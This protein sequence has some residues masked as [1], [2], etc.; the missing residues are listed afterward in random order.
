MSDTIQEHVDNDLSIIMTCGACPESYDVYRGNDCVG[1][2]RLRHGYFAAS[3]YKFDEVDGDDVVYESF[4]KGDGIF[5]SDER[6]EEIN[7]ALR[8][9]AKYIFDLKE[10]PTFTVSKFNLNTN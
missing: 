8:E 10:E 1:K 2:L 7:K 9:I 3:A 5:E 6:D 4:P